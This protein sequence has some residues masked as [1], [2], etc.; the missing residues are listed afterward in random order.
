M[1]Q[2]LLYSYTRPFLRPDSCI[3][4]LIKRTL[5][6]YTCFSWTF[7]FK[8]CTSE[9]Q[10]VFLNSCVFCNGERFDDWQL[11]V[12]LELMQRTDF[13]SSLPNGTQCSDG[14]KSLLLLQD[15]LAP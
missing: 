8:T 3:S 12:R 7:V 1:L 2:R 13:Y 4:H 5:L 9:N 10:V 14:D 6:S 15:S 11:I